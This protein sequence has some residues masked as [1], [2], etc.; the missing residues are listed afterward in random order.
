ME[1]KTNE[2]PSMRRTDTTRVEGTENE[3][4]ISGVRNHLLKSM[5]T[6]GLILVL[7]LISYSLWRVD[8]KLSTDTLFFSGLTSILVLYYLTALYSDVKLS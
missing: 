1:K 6:I 5:N 8:G 7:A 4:A 2:P 3:S